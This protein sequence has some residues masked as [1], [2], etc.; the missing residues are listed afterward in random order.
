MESITSTAESGAH[1]CCCVASEE[2]IKAEIVHLSSNSGQALDK[3]IP[4]VG[5]SDI[6]YRGLSILKAFHDTSY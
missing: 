2:Q 3:D 4:L 5:R 6:K 1:I